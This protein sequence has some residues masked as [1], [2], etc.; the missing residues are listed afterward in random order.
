MQIWQSS[1]AFDLVDPP[2]PSSL[3]TTTGQDCAHAVSLS[4]SWPA[5]IYLL[6]LILIFTLLNTQQSGLVQQSGNCVLRPTGVTWPLPGPGTAG[7]RRRGRFSWRMVRVPMMPGLHCHEVVSH[8]IVLLSPY[9]LCDLILKH[10]ELFCVSL[11]FLFLLN[12]DW[13]EC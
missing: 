9:A 5:S 11:L 7:W 6:I 8:S 12:Q 3:R 2:W 13:A 4:I 10:A 1:L